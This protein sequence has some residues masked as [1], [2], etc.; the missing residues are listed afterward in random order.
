MAY[1]VGQVIY[2]LSSETDKIVPMQV[3]EELR[4]RTI[5][6]EE[7]S[8]LISSGPDKASFRLDEVKGKVFT[9]LENAREHLKANFEVW[10]EKQVEWTVASQRAWYRMAPSEEPKP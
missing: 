1:D 8:Y 5:N 7:V 2:V 4:R 9:T 3:S 6:G 10:L